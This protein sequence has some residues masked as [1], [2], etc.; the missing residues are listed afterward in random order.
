ME[1]AGKIKHLERWR[2]LGHSSIWK[3]KAGD[4]HASGKKKL[5]TSGRCDTGIWRLLE[6]LIEKLRKLKYSDKKSW[7]SHTFLWNKLRNLKHFD[8]GGWGYS[9]IWKEQAGSFLAFWWSK[10][11]NLK[12]FDRGSSELSSEGEP[13]SRRI[14]AVEGNN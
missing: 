13:W 1:E 3:K 11:G 8:R 12:H 2:K 6:I 14:V 9:S 10:L 4:I 5:E 7:K